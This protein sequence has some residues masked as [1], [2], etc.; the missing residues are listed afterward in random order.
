M[1]VTIVT[2]VPYV[3]PVPVVLNVSLVLN[4][5][6]VPYEVHV[7]VAQTCSL[8]ASAAAATRLAVPAAAPKGITLIAAALGIAFHH[9]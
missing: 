1:N 6:I 8:D 4:V 3:T 5:P 7:Q 9:R 2:I